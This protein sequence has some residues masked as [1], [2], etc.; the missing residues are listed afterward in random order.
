MKNIPGLIVNNLRILN[1]YPRWMK[2]VPLVE[3]QLFISVFVDSCTFLS[4]LNCMYFLVSSVTTH[5]VYMTTGKTGDV[6]ARTAASAQERLPR[7]SEFGASSS[8]TSSTK[9]RRQQD[10]DSSRTLPASTTI[11]GPLHPAPIQWPSS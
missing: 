10:L 1:S 5:P 6:S 8:Q 2:P 4:H 9:E 11:E 3:M 7:C